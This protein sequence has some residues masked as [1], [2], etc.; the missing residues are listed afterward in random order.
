MKR[1][2]SIVLV[3][4]LLVGANVTA[5]AEEGMEECA[6]FRDGEGSYLWTG[7]TG[8]LTLEVALG[9]EACP[10]VT[11]ELWVV[12][13]GG[14]DIN[15]P[16]AT[17]FDLEGPAEPGAA[18]LLT[19]STGGSGDTLNYA[20]SVTDNDPTVCIFSVSTR[21]TTTTDETDANGNGT[22]VDDQHKNNSGN[23][24]DGSKFEWETT[25]N[26]ALIDRAPDAGCLALNFAWDEA[27]PVLRSVVG[28]GGQGYN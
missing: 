7:E 18:E 21:T 19:S 27:Y 28:G 25:S 1:A 4:G 14:D 26:A 2:F 17:V 9:A 16:S 6:D 22:T 20:L 24:S 15:D 23:N 5:N 8:D 10:D 11:Y 12:R 13:D 3:L